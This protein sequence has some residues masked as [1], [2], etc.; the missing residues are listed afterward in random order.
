MIP[1]VAISTDMITG[2][3]G[4]TEEEHAD[5]I[6][7]MEYCAFDQAFMFAYSLR[8]KTHASHNMVDDVPVEVK[9]RRLQEVIDVYR[10]KLK[11][12]NSLTETFRKRLVLVEGPATRSSAEAPMWTGRTDGN[13]R[14]VFSATNA[15]LPS[16][17]SPHLPGVLSTLD[18]VGPS[19]RAEVDAS[20]NAEKARNDG[21]TA[22]KIQGR[23]TRLVTDT[24][25]AAMRTLPPSDIVAA[26]SNSNFNNNSNSNSNSNSSS[27][28]HRS[29]QPGDYVVVYIAEAEGP[30]LR[31]AAFAKSSMTE[32]HSHQLHTAYKHSAAAM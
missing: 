28:H 2:F 27:N 13:K 19:L 32:F 8:D 7:L 29:I 4:E 3:C 26:D 12:K 30:T 5:T 10:R 24:L 18:L 16:L 9:N 15:V 17:H 20:V 21:Q 22:E 23:L 11:E 14:V 25:D 6:S 31:G 1:G